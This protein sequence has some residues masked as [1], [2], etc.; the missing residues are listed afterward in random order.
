MKYT[1]ATFFFLF[2]LTI[3]S[4]EYIHLGYD[5]YGNRT[6]RKLT[7]VGDNRAPAPSKT[8]GTDD[9]NDDATSIDNV[10]GED[11][12]QISP[13]EAVNQVQVSIQEIGGDISLSLYS[14][15]GQLLQQQKVSDGNYTLDLSNYAPGVYILSLRKQEQTKE[16]KIVKK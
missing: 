11:K 6:N 2:S 1:L 5:S 12:V 16:Y 14:S 13:D 9:N 8:K 7:Y 4:Q 10:F 15:S 3:Y